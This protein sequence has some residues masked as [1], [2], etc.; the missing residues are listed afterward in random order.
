MAQVGEFNG[1]SVDVRSHVDRLVYVYIVYMDTA[2]RLYLCRYGAVS[3]T[4]A[5]PPQFVWPPQFAVLRSRIYT[6]SFQGISL[7]G[8]RVGMVPPAKR[9]Q[10]VLRSLP[11]YH[12]YVVVSWPAALTDKKEP[13][14]P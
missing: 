1:T 8:Y 13:Q 3:S 5:R 12:L 2:R 6:S 4:Y 9:I 7:C 14:E 10:G 11:G